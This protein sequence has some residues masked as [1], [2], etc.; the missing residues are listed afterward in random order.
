MDFFR[1]FGGFTY[2]HITFILYKRD[3]CSLLNIGY[4]KV[5]NR[6]AVISNVQYQIS[7]SQSLHIGTY[8]K[9]VLFD[10]LLASPKVWTGGDSDSPPLQCKCSALPNELPARLSCTQ[11]S[12]SIVLKLGKANFLPRQMALGV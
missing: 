8:L 7:N 10:I 2:I 11:S 4:V 6:K 3:L 1:P 9:L 12:Q 5:Q